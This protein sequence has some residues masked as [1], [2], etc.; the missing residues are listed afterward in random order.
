MSA[1]G[2]R[3]RR[4]PAPIVLAAALAA[5]LPGCARKAAPP[6]STLSEA[7]RDSVLAREPI[8]GADAI[9]RA[10]QAAGKEAAHAAGVDSTAR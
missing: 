9:G 2:W 3:W 8:P 5:A 7:Q 6:A 10:R 4:V 1:P